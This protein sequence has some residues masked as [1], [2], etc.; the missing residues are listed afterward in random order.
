MTLE[1]VKEYKERAA[2]TLKICEGVLTELKEVER[3]AEYD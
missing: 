1:V 3:N 2:S